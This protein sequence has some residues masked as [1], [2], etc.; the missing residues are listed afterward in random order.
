MANLLI[1]NPQ[2]QKS[3]KRPWPARRTKIVATVGPA[4]EQPRILKE[5]IR[6]GAD[7]L[8][9]NTSHT[10]VEG[11]Q[12]WIRLIR[13]AGAEIKKEI[14]I[15]VDLQGPRIRTGSLKDKKPVMLRKGQLVAIVPG[16]TGEDNGVYQI[17]TP[18]LQ[19]PAM[20]KKG[21][22]IL[23][24]N[25]LI[26]LEV[27]S[28]EKKE[29]KCRVAS[30]GILGENKGINLPHA[31][32][33]LPAL[34]DKDI[35]IVRMAAALEVD[36]IA[37]SFVRTPGDILSVQK[38][39]DRCEKSIPI[40]AKIEKPM[41]VEQIDAIIAV[42]HG[43]MVARGDL[44]IELG[45]EKVPVIQKQLI[46]KANQSSL[47]VI[48]ATQM[49]E[50]MM[51]HSRPTRAEASDV[52]NA[53]FDGTDA[54]ML[55]GETSIGK[56]P[57]ET[58]RMMSEIIC[59][60]EEHMRGQAR[61]VRP[62]SSRKDHPLCAISYAAQNAAAHIDAKAIVAFTLSGKTAR[63]VSKFERHLPILAFTPSAAVSRRLMLCR[64]VIPL[65]IENCHSTD[66]MLERGERVLSQSKLLKKG[67]AVVVLSSAHAFHGA[68]YMVLIHWIGGMPR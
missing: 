12:E 66:E 68:N 42:S 54:V 21:D 14:P 3:A 29:I 56:Y 62:I 35:E 39:L 19:F 49:L 4:C 38:M 65:Q 52:A 18:C 55:S 13:S 6:Q 2:K 8:R 36:F 32:T 67:D 17:S 59:E 24:D 28:V 31:P 51:E 44:G 48:T 43:I 58:V 30:T 41:A 33:T 50:S 15:L 20:V 26:D 23:I 40:I 45:V 47:P 25:G 57:L 27:L 63:M 61:T 1:S 34:S 5:L 11:L 53:V 16:K 9:I 60:A 64:G 46:E 37:L 22:P 7:I 10:S